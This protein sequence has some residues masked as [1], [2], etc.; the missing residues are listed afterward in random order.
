[1]NVM[2]IDEPGAGA[3][4]IIGAMAWRARPVQDTLECL[5]WRARAQ[6]EVGVAKVCVYQLSSTPGPS[7]IA[8]WPWDCV[9]D[10]RFE[11]PAALRLLAVLSRN[12][13][14]SLVNN[15]ENVKAPL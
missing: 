2:G 10:G 6:L 3:I 13:C 11:H 8:K 9:G 1:M 4:D 14:S 12:I 7:S 15:T 5:K